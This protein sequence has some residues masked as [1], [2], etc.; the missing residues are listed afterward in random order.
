MI[1]GTHLIIYS[2]DAEA[3]RAY[4]RDVLGMDNIDIGG[5]WL[6]FKAP[7]AEI[8][9]HPN[10]ANGRHELYFMCDDVKKTIAE[11]EVKKV[12]C[13]AVKEERWGSLTMVTLPGGGELG[14]YQPKHAVIAK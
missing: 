11:L 13:S 6:I 5:G 4:F 9:F 14:I 8:A 3:D 2:T 1:T 12:K 7:P 10:S